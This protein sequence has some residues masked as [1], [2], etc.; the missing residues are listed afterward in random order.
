MG[1]VVI[2]RTEGDSWDITTS[3]GS[4]ALFVATARALAG[5]DPSALAVDP[6]AEVFVRAAGP[7]WSPMLDGGAPAELLAE[8]EFGRA[9]QEFQAARTRYFD[10]FVAAAIDSDIR[11]VVILAAGL[12]AR[13]YRLHWPEDAIVYELDRPRVLEFKRETLAANGD[14]PLVDRREVVAD[15]R[16]DWPRALREQGFDPTRPTAWLVEGLL[17]YLP[18]TAQ[19]QLFDTIDA[20]STAGSRVAVEQMDPL[21]EEAAAAI[22]QMPDEAETGSS[23]QWTALIYNEPRSEVTAWLTAHDWRA[24]RTDVPDYLRAHGRP[25]PNR[26]PQEGLVPALVSLVTGIRS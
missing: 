2:M 25:V 9:F 1:T 10:D 13:A 17:I 14:K 18:A 24:E 5:R 19:E 3:V 15:L 7:E 11:Q 23:G 26:D 16:E 6:F 21:P 20:L 12:D 8:S 4:T 22:G